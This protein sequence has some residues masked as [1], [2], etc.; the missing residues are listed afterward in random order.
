MEQNVG[1]GDP[2][3]LVVVVIC[4]ERLVHRVSTPTPITSET[5]RALAE[6]ACRRQV[7]A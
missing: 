3:K 4:D 7:V 1:H 6:K 2:K 5:E